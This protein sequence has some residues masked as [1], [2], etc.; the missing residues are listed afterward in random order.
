ME[1]KEEEKKDYGSDGASWL[2]IL[3]SPVWVM[4]RQLKIR[5]GEIWAVALVTVI[6]V[7]LQAFFIARHW[8]FCTTFHPANE[9]VKNVHLSGF[10]A[11]TYDTIT[12]WGFYYNVYRH[13]LMPYFMY[14][15]HLL[16]RL[17]SAVTGIN[18][19]QFVVALMLLFCTVYS[20]AFLYRLLRNVIGVGHIDATLLTVLTWSFGYVM[21]SGIVPDHFYISMF[22][23]IA[24]L[25]CSGVLI[26]RGR[27][28]PMRLSIPLFFLVAGVSLNNGVKVFL[29]QLFVN[30]KRFFRPKYL[31]FS[32]LIPSA[33]IWGSARAIY[34]INVFP[35]WK[36][37]QDQ[38]AKNIKAKDDKSLEAFKKNSGVTDSAILAQEYVKIQKRNEAAREKRKQSSVWAKHSGKPF[39]KGEFWSWT[40]ATTSRTE[41]LVHNVFGE[42]LILHAEGLLGDALVNRA[43]IVKY[44]NP[45]NYVVCAIVALLFLGG[46]VAGW[47]SRL[48]WLALSWLGFD[49]FIH[50]ILGFG[51]NEI[52]IMSA[53]WLFIIPIA[54]AYLLKKA[55]GW[56][57]PALRCVILPLI[58]YMVAY[59]AFYVIKYLVG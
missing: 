38:N 45:V 24:T 25:Y 32:V 9:Y 57:K 13:P 5:R 11:L 36:A 30:G 42:S 29:S 34:Y 7:V 50:L 21:V 18:C 51:I 59:N 19:V 3:M 12:D 14:P 40:D 52:Y 4:I 39:K 26:Q 1:V 54:T 28:M 6:N 8:F 58:I 31:L 33:L 37:R 53:H 22:L 47:R 35:D 49:M 56:Q 15:F 16:N 46:I 23:L 20:A 48:L 43:V 41:T 27:R 10:D 2:A 55:K 44:H 17:L